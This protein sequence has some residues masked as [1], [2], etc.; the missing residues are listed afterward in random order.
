VSSSASGYYVVKA[1]LNGCSVKDSVNVTIKTGPAALTASANTPVCGGDT[2]KLS[3]ANTSTVTWAW[4]GPGSFSSSVQSPGMPNVQSAAAGRYYVTATTSNGCYRKDSVDITVNPSPADCIATS[5]TPIC[6]GDTLKLNGASTT[7]GVSY[8]WA[9]PG[10]FSSALQSLSLSNAQPTQS[11]NYILS[12]TLNN[13]SAKDTEAVIIKATPVVP[14]LTANTPVCTG[15]TLDLNTTALTGATYQW[16][17]P[18]G[19]IASVQNATRPGI[20]FAMAGFY[21]LTIVVNGCISVPDSI[22]VNVLLAPNVTIA[23]DPGDTICDGSIIRFKSVLSGS[24][25]RYKYQWYKN[26]F[27]TGVSSSSYTDNSPTDNDT[28]FCVITASGSCATSYIDTSNVISLSVLPVLAAGIS[29]NAVPNGPVAIG[30]LITF[31]TMA[32]NGGNNPAYQWRLNGTDLPGVTSGVWSSNNL[33]NSDVICV[34]MT[35]NY[36]CAQPDTASSCVGVLV[37]PT[38][39]DK[40]KLPNGLK[41]YPNPV[42]NELTIEGIAKGT[43]IQL[44][45]VL[46]RLMTDMT[47]AKEIELVNTSNLIKGTYLLRLTDSNNHKIDAKLVKD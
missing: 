42:T 27:S 37:Y 28:Y 45:D 26:A 10:G 23:A 40:T 5:N 7:T 25:T 3:A 41:I 35:S 12:V 13:C 32:V 19:Y 2:L 38:A 6:Q 29:I 47:S 11:G 43:R 24:A 22:P 34:F 14:P 15:Q 8:S 33:N 46:G 20:T 21:K 9:G 36:T 4:T 44:Y 31:N 39:V 17:G 30:D 18:G 1:T 16:E